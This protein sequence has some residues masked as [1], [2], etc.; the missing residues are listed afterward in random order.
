M[1]VHFAKCP[2]FFDGLS[3]EDCEWV[4]NSVNMQ[5][6]AGRFMADVKR[7]RLKR[8]QF[9]Q[10]VPSPAVSEFVTAEK[11]CEG[12]TI[13]GIKIVRLGENFKQHL[14]K[15]VETAVPE[16][17]L[18]EHRLVVVS[19]DTEIITELGGEQGPETSLAH[20]WASL[21]SAVHSQWLLRYVR[22]AE[23]VLWSVNAYWRE[24]GLDI[25]A[26]RPERLVGGW[27]ADHYDIR[28]VSR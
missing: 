27:R 5:S 25:E 1:L 12:K 24:G 23:G 21:A 15:K 8:L 19:R 14:L 11:F 16:R 2:H 4:T 18:Q 9:V 7:A 22:D 13:D 6:M 17:T 20:L 28:V 3:A 10:H 26:S